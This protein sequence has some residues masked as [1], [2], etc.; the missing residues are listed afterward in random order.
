MAA[1]TV[2]ALVAGCGVRERRTPDDTIVIL[3]PNLIRDLDPRFTIS[4]YDT[5]LSRLVVPGLTT[6]DSESM[7]PALEL[8]A[9][10]DRYG[11]DYTWLVTLKPGLRFS[12][13]E[14][15]T[16]RDVAWTYH[17]VL[18]PATRSL[19]RNA[20]RD[21]FL[22]VQVVD[23]R[24][25]L[26]HLMAPIATLFSDLDFGIV[27]RTAAGD[28]GLFDDRP[29]VGAGAFRVESESPDDA[30]LVRNPNYWGEP[31]GVDRVRV[32]V[33]RD[34]NARALMLVG[35]SADIV[36]NSV[37]MDL[38]DDIANRGRVHVTR[39]PSAI[40]SYLMMNNDHP[41]LGDVRVRRA[42]A[43]AVDREG[44]V[45]AKFQGR[46]VLATGLI[47]P[48]HW[49]YNPDVDRY[50]H[51]LERAGALL[52]AAG[53]PDPDGPGPQPR[54]RLTYKTSADAFR[55]AVAR[56]IA[57][58]LGAVGIEVDVQSF[59]FGTFFMDVKKGNFELGSMQTSAITEPDLT[60]TYFHSERVPRPDNIHLHNRWR[61]RNPE[62][63]RLVE[64][65]RREMDRERRVAI[66]ART[67]EILARDVP[68]IPLWHE[69]NVAVM[70][71][72]LVGYRVLP[73][74]RLR[75]LALARKD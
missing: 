26:F 49:A 40:L 64:A 43:H 66:Y 41:I 59:E 70:N 9:S 54:F 23:D 2:A 15:L 21:R 75:G 11:S 5:K 44:I 72:S 4:N 28:D 38:V 20:F 3:T 7:A 10:I 71:T 74:A 16:A 17:S 53:Y 29:V 39:G 47:P 18:D 13:G 69:D 33:V 56:I 63:D 73:N 65:G 14:P 37:R 51:D 58:Q 48:G 34:Q 24:R 60:Y 55:V 6:T 27:S 36:Q 25:V 50:R 22:W 57:H 35:G 62:L 31:A 32:R 45:D 52:D 67:Q 68:I 19:H 1:V 30:V 61:Y 42:I 12:D 46:A 8:A